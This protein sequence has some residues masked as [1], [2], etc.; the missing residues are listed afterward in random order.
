MCRQIYS[1]TLGEGCVVCVRDG[2]LRAF[3][4]LKKLKC[5]SL[6]YQAISVRFS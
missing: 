3:L 2:R 6:L 4:Q 5:S 1:H